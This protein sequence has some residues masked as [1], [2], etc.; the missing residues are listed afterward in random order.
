MKIVEFRRALLEMF[1]EEKL[2]INSNAE[3]WVKG[4]EEP[5]SCPA[6]RGLSRSEK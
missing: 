2:L 3:E 6:S 1:E 5:K 4:E